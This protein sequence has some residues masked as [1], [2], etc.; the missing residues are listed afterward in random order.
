MRIDNLAWDKKFDEIR[1]EIKK[2]QSV[3]SADRK[4]LENLKS[5][6]QEFDSKLRN[7]DREIEANEDHIK[8]QKLLIADNQK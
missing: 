4:V 7:F 1:A 2:A 3:V 5:Q 8:D 6:Q